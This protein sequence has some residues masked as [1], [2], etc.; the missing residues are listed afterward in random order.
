M[1]RRTALRIAE[2]EPILPPRRR[3]PVKH[4]A[5]II[6]ILACCIS[7]SARG[8]VWGSLRLRARGFSGESVDPHARVRG[9]RPDRGGGEAAPDLCRAAASDLDGVGH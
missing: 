1:L 3:R 4:A 6:G 2:R 8:F 7:N 9:L 5:I